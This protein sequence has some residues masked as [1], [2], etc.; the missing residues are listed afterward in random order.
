MNIKLCEAF[1]LII[2]CFV[3]MQVFLEIPSS[4][5][6]NPNDMSLRE[7]TNIIVSSVG[8]KFQD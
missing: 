6:D 2:V 3:V 7:G 4:E 5:D 8:M 1:E